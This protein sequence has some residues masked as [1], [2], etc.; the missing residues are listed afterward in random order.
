MEYHAG[1][2]FAIIYDSKFLGI[3]RIGP[4]LLAFAASDSKTREQQE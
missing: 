4:M 2:F 3:V 1:R